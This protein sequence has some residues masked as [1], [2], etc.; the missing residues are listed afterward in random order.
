M[1]N[2]DY[3]YHIDEDTLILGDPRAPN[4]DSKWELFVLSTKLIR[5][6]SILF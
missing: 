2:C 3:S 5:K 1:S 6:W 4:Y